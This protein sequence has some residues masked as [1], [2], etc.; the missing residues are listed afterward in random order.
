MIADILLIVVLPAIVIAALVVLLARRRPG[1]EEFDSDS[2]GFVGG[3]LNALFVVVLAFYIVFAWQN[4]DDAGNQ[5]AAEANAVVDVYWDVSP[6]PSAAAD[7]IRA[8]DREYA[9]EVIS[10]EWAD[11]GA[12]HTDPKASELLDRLRAEAS[13]LPTDPESVKDARQ[14]ALSDIQTIDSNH[15]ARISAATESANFTVFLLIGTIIGAVIMLAFP[16]ILGL[17]A[18]PSTIISMVL[19]AVTLGAIIVISLQLLH[20]LS[21]P[22]G[23]TTS[24]YRD[25][26]ADTSSP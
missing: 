24:P 19:L 3:V 15:S 20:P 17:S 11:L 8:T 22:F 13:A 10:H 26:L 25:A 18:K 16:L 23:A 12:G 21:G 4:G 5:A 2:L 6:A 7:A 1:V 14:S 9:Q